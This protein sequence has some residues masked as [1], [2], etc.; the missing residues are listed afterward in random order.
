MRL[1]DILHREVVDAEGRNL[2]EVQDILVSQDGPQR[3]G[4]DATM[5]V[6]GLVVG[7]GQGTRLG[8]ERGG[9]QGPWPLSAI[10]RRLERR[11]RFVPWDAVTFSDSG[12]LRV[13][14][15]AE[16]FGPPPTS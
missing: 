4:H 2:G 16:S 8:F 15:S 5:V 10:F 11:A 9:A 3:G 6:E 1:S 7:G 13:Q 12:P 14:R